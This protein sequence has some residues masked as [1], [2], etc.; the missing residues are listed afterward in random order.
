MQNLTQDL[1]KFVIK[2]I[3]STKFTLS[4]FAV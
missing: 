1:P 3:I 4:F 2:I